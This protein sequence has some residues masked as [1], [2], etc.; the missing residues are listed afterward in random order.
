MLLCASSVGAEVSGNIELGGTLLGTTGNRSKLNEYRDLGNGFTLGVG[1]DANKDD[2]YFQLSGEN[3][4]Y[5]EETRLDNREV[6]FSAKVGQYGSNKLSIYY[7]QIPH[8][9]SLGAKTFYTGGIGT[10]N[11]TGPIVNNN[12][13]TW[14]TRFDY[15]RDRTNYG[16]AAELSFKSPYFFGIKYDRTDMQG[17]NPTGTRIRNGATNFFSEF[18]SVVD[19]KTDNVFLETG[20]RSKAVIFKVDGLISQFNNPYQ[21]MTIPGMLNAATSLSP[22]TLPPNNDYYKV[23]GSLMVHLPLNSTLMARANHSI[24]ENNV[25]LTQFLAGSPQFH[26]RVTY[27][28]ASLAV[29]SNPV[30]MLETRIFYNLLDKQNK[31]TDSFVYGG[32]TTEKFAYHKQNVGVDASLSLPASTIVSAGYEFQHL[33]RALRADAYSTTDHTVFVEAKNSALDML[34][35]KVRLEHLKRF[36]DDQLVPTAT[37]IDSRF[38]RFDATDKSQES[39]KVGLEIE[40]LHN[41]SIG[42]EYAFKVDLFDKTDIGVTS[43]R[44]HEFNFDTNYSIANVKL[45]AYFDYEYS[46]NKYS[47]HAGAFNVPSGTATVYDYAVKHHNMAFDYGLNADVDIIKN[48]LT[49]GLGWRYD[50]NDGNLAF[51]TNRTTGFVDIPA[52][53][54]YSRQTLTAKLGYKV[55]KNLGVNCGYSY[56]RLKYSE[57]ELNNYQNIVLTGAGATSGYLTGAFANQSYEAHIGYVKLAYNF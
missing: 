2:L 41:L 42:M 51:T 49:A 22:L 18:P 12:V 3:F 17:L 1:L 53:N 45:N 48:V 15:K 46:L 5:N 36:S 7:N 16:A 44:R 57:A 19:Y 10:N 37:S 8:N 4:R 20:Y 28:T 34:T 39:V 11:L 38:R 14:N 43:D 30:K 33:N 23:G 29:T 35:A 54:D 6:D 47:S 13:A 25:D 52:D 56:E 26:G 31:S 55:T 50:K 24:L 27:T 21:T 9:V 32:A 40:P